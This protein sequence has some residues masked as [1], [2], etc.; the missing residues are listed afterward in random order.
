M[1][2]KRRSCFL[3]RSRRSFNIAR[4]QLERRWPRMWTS[5]REWLRTLSQ[6]NSRLQ[7]NAP[8][9]KTRGRVKPTAFK[10]LSSDVH[11]PQEIVA[12][13]QLHDAC[14][15]KAE[16]M[17]EGRVAARAKVAE[18]RKRQR[19]EQIERRTGNTCQYIESSS[20]CNSLH[21][22]G[23]AWK[24]C[25]VCHTFKICP[26]HADLSD[27]LLRAHIAKCALALSATKKTPEPQTQRA[28]TESL[29]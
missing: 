11:D 6:R 24:T 21:H 27:E 4:R 20:R 10:V 7:L 22:G 1:R 18:T 14:V 29:P 28:R 16:T 23:K 15:A 26:K 9:Q 13:G 2:L 8:K 3:G 19:E 5:W 25:G 12:L 17:K